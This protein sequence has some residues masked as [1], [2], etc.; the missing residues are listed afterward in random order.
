[1]TGRFKRGTSPEDVALA[2]AQGTTE[3]TD[4]RGFESE[5]L[6]V[7]CPGES[8]LEKGKVVGMLGIVVEESG[9]GRRLALMEEVVVVVE[10]DAC[11][12]GIGIMNVLGKRKRHN[13]RGKLFKEVERGIDD[14]NGGVGGRVDEGLVSERG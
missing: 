6:A 4:A 5:G 8:A 7:G 9:A 14:M 10:L 12:G 3:S 11:L 13:L 2:S 1:M